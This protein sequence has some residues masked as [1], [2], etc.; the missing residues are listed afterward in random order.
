MEFA[1]NCSKN[2]VACDMGDEF[3]AM[4]NNLICGMAMSTRNSGSV[5]ESREIR[6]V[7]KGITS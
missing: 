2:G 7:M 6:E 5:N 1:A 3:M 4:I